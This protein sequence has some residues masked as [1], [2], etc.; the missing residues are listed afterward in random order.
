MGFLEQVTSGKVKKPYSLMIFGPDGC[1]KST[2]AAKAPAAIFLGSEDGTNQLDVKRL[3]K[4]NSF[5]DALAMIEELRKEKHGYETLVVDSLD[6]IEPMLWKDVCKKNDW[7]TIDSPGYGRGYATALAEWE[8]MKNSL[9]NLREEKNMNLVLIA[10]S[11][12]KTFMDPAS[13]IGYDRYVLKLHDGPSAMFRE[14][15]DAV[16][17]ANFEVFTKGKQGQKGTAVGDG[18]RVMFTERRPA[19][20]A[21]N[22]Y[23]LPFQMKL[24]W[25]E[26]VKAAEKNNDS[27]ERLKDS[28]LGL[29]KNVVD[30]ELKEKVTKAVENANA[31]VGKLGKILGKLQITVGG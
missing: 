24:S 9:Y 17:F 28:I 14:M 21:K 26:F 10:H 27:P 5:G 15:V 1:G 25:D 29:L 2:F 13:N 19:F 8:R 30:Q 20:D 31:D 3:P 22:R 12:I 18:E 11:K 16:L 6:W 7:Q 4:P 23:G